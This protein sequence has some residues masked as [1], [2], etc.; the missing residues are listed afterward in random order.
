[1]SR[2]SEGAARELLEHRRRGLPSVSV[3][4]AAQL[5]GAS[6]TTVAGVEDGRRARLGAAASA[7]RG[8][9]GR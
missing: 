2:M 4:L 1:M 9:H 5:L 3:A 7:S 8:Q 6:R